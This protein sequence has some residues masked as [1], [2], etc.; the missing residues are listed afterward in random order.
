MTTEAKPGTDAEGQV[1]ATG[2]AEA[3]GASTPDLEAAQAKIEKLEKDIASMRGRVRQVNAS[4]E[5]IA[6]SEERQSTVLKSVI[7]TILESDDP[8]ERK[9]RVGEAFAVQQREAAL[10]KEITA[11]QPRLQKIVDDTG[12]TWESADEFADARQAWDAGNPKEALALARLAIAG[13]ATGM[14]P[15]SAEFKEAVATEVRNQ[16]TSEANQVDSGGSTGG[17]TGGE[18]PAS[19]TQMLEIIKTRRTAGNPVTAAEQRAMIAHLG[20]S[21]ITR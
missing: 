7:D 15:N 16:R 13:Q 1:K 20:G 12:L 9:Q 14:A 19:P 21:V 4:A 17:T 11:T 5:A 3:G 18:M 8:D 6:D 10:A 2:D